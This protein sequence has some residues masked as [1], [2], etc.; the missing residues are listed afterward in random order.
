MVVQL[1]LEANGVLGADTLLIGE[2]RPERMTAFPN[3][4]A[5]E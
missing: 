5:G 3:S 1:E 2:D 4:A